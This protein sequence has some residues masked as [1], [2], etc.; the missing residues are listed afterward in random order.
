MN[1][2][3]FIKFVFSSLILWCFFYEPGNEKVQKLNHW[4]VTFECSNEVPWCSEYNAKKRSSL[5][6]TNMDKNLGLTAQL[7]KDPSYLFPKMVNQK[8]PGFSNCTQFKY[9][10]S[11]ILTHLGLNN[12]KKNIAKVSFFANKTLKVQQ[13]EKLKIISVVGGL[14]GKTQ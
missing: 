13:P 10:T 14:V 7:K 4:H 3:E 1:S 6:L 8:D 9:Y 2:A 12:N 5:W 11:V